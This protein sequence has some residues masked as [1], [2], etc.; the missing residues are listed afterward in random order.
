MSYK[1]ALQE[2]FTINVGKLVFLQE[3]HTTTPLRPL[4]LSSS[5]C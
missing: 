3:A 1:E 4:L 5:Q 2:S